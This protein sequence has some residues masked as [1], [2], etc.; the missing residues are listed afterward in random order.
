M[1]FFFLP[2][3]ARRLILV[4]TFLTAAYIAIDTAVWLVSTALQFPLLPPFTL[5][6]A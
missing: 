2:A 3:H 4:V 1:I 5:A 6:R